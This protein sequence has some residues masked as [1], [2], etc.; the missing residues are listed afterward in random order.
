MKQ[1][2]ASG[3]NLEPTITG[4]NEKLIL[5]S[6]LVLLDI[7]ESGNNLLLRGKLGALLEL[8]VTNSARKSKVAVDATEIDKTSSS[9]NTVLLGC[10]AVWAARPIR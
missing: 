5:I 3:R 2:T 6:Q 9:C 4:K 1:R 7:G 10:K 8:E